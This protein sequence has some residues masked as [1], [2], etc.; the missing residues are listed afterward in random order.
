[1]S[2]PALDAFTGIG[3]EI[4]YMIVDTGDLSVRP[5][6]DRLLRQAAGEDASEVDRGMLGWSNELALHVIEVKNPR[7]AATMEGLAGAFHNEVR[8]INRLLH[9][10]SARLMPGAM[11]PWMSPP[12]DL[13]LWPHDPHG[14]YRGYQRIF[15]TATHG[16]ANLQSMHLNLPFA[17]DAQFERLHAAVRLVLPVIPA[18]AASSPV[19]DGADTGFADYRMEVYRTNASDFPAIAGLVIPPTVGSRAQYEERILAPMYRE[20]A[21]HDP[22]RVLQQEWLNSHGAIAR[23]DRNAIEIRV[24]DTQECP[25]ADL[26]VAAAIVAAVQMLYR[27]NCAPLDAQQALPTAR[28]A[29]LLQACIRDADEALIDDGAYLTLLGYPGRACRAG[30]L[31]RHLAQSMPHDGLLRGARWQPALQ[32]ML[33]HGPLARRIRRALNGDHAPARL[34]AVYR[35]LC[36]CLEQGAMFISAAD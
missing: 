12:D 32:C 25:Q 26:A 8:A 34:Q 30:E 21:P 13:R 1:M 20:I 23:F 28:L 14:I 27:E 4:E 2:S 19:A 10:D 3:I 5:I 36:D 11:H 15:D 6:A 35:E 33:E 7:P 18:L 16:W 24:I 22:A 29:A 17:D 9:D 31:W